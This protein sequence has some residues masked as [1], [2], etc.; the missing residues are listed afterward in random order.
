MKHTFI[1]LF[2]ALAATTAAQ[3]AMK[4]GEAPSQKNTTVAASPSSNKAQASIIVNVN[5]MSRERQSLLNEVASQYRTS[6]TKTLLTTMMS[7]GAMSLFS[8]VEDEA[9]ALI[10]MRD[11]KERAWNE[12]R[13]RENHFADSL[14]SIGG[15]HDFYNR[16]SQYGPLD[17]SNMKFDGIT[18]SAYRNG[19][20]VLRMVCH[21]DTSRFNEL[22]LHSRFHLVLDSLVFRLY[23]AFLP[24]LGGTFSSNNN[25]DLSE[26]LVAYKNTIRRFSFREQQSPEVSISIDLYSSWINDATQIFQDVKLGSFAINVTIREEDL[27]DSVY[28]YSRQQAIS[29]GKPVITMNGN[30]FVVPR[31]Y[32]PVSFDQPSWGTGEY[33]M[34]VR[35]AEDCHTNPEGKRAKNWKKD[36][37][38]VTK[39]QNH[40]KAKHP[41]IDHVITTFSEDGFSIIKAIYDPAVREALTFESKEDATPSAETDAKKPGKLQGIPQGAPQSKPQ[42]KKN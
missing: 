18:L 15:Q 1:I 3:P 24:N 33:K 25:E 11:N 34:K 36:Y 16:P 13:N 31:S 5:S 35:I 7:A 9:R 29:E 21:L 39:I 32:M 12:Q 6:R 17:P 40:G 22:F 19:N 38:N 23:D 26:E 20:E 42:H 27:K 41:Y 30:S 8:I 2:L 4:K 10:H 14:Q 37:K 28:T